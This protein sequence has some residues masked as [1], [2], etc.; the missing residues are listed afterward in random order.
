MSINIITEKSAAAGMGTMTMGI[1]M[2]R[3]AAAGM[4]IIMKRDAA[5]GMSIIMAQTLHMEQGS[6]RRAR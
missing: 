1:V 6:S 2:K 4:G 5:A 3:A